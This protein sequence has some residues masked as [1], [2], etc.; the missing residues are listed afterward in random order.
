MEPLSYTFKQAK[1][2]KMLWLALLGFPVLVMP[3]VFLVIIY[4]DDVPFEGA[5]LLYTIFLLLGAGVVLYFVVRKKLLGNYRLDLLEDGF[6]CVGLAGERDDRYTWDQVKKVREGFREDGNSPRE[7]L[8]I[9]VHGGAPMFL[10]EKKG[11]KPEI[12]LEVFRAEFLQAWQTATEVF[13]DLEEDDL[14]N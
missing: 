13:P 2:Q 1:N 14:G 8:W 7:Y 9:W 12:S 6:R 3:L 4:L 5:G 10:E 11:T